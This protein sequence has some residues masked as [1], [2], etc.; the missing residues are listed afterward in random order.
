MNKLEG[1]E[2]LFGFMGW[3]TSRDQV[4]TFSSSHDAAIAVELIEKFCKAN[5]L[6][7]GIR[8]DWAKNLTHPTNE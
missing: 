5:N 3:L 6:K 2:I 1:A 8:D 4:E 7:T